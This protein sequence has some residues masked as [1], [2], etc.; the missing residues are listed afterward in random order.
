MRIRA[1]FM[2]DPETLK[3]LRPNI[4]QFF[5]R[6]VSTTSGAASEGNK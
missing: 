3:R 6:L 2:T 1:L 4:F 5:E